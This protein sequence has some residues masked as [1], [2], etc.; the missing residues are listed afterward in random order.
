[1]DAS[2]HRNEEKA[3]AEAR[4]AH[5]AQIKKDRDDQLALAEKRRS[6][7]AAKKH[8]EE[9]RAHTSIPGAHNPSTPPPPL[10]CHPPHH[11]T[12]EAACAHAGAAGRGQARRGGSQGC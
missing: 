11:A 9:A 12:D 3:K 1:V 5:E 10:T 7:A 6:E 2:V 8:A 4:R